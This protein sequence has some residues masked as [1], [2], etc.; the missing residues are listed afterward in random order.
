MT[1]NS[2]AAQ[3]I[4]KIGAQEQDAA[5][6]LRFELDYLASLTVQQR[7]EMMFRRSR[8]LKEMLLEYG[9]REPVEIVKR[10]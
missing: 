5:R 8:H 3:G 9:H 4:L 10:V 2:E 7:F 1:A 6:E